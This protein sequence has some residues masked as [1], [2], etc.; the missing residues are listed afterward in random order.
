MKR[1]FTIVALPGVGPDHLP[2]GG[3]QS[4]ERAFEREGD[5]REGGAK[6]KGGNEQAAAGSRGGG[7]GGL[8]RAA[9]SSS[10]SSPPPPA[11]ALPEWVQQHPDYL[12]CVARP[13]DQE[14]AAKRA[15][16]LRKAMRLPP[17]ERPLSSVR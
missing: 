1:S 7:G 3:V 13:L 16:Q 2:H 15:Q 4:I 6:G 8:S 12:E 9:S 10:S 11:A 5:E 14:S 17:D